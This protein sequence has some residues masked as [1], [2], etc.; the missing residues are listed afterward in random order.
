MSKLLIVTA[1]LY[2]IA[3]A[4]A[5]AGQCICSQFGNYTYCQCF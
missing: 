2:C 4:T 5:Y 1:S 3:M